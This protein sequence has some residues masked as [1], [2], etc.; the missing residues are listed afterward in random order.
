MA[1]DAKD[2]EMVPEGGPEEVPKEGDCTALFTSVP[3]WNLE[4]RWAFTIKNALGRCVPD[5][6]FSTL[7]FFGFCKTSR[8]KVVFFYEV[9]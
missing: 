1:K 7:L 8:L 4:G 6:V 9:T 5:R 2:A 3:P